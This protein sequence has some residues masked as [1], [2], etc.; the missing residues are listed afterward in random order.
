MKAA[1]IFQSYTQ[2]IFAEAAVS[3]SASPRASY[4]VNTLLALR[5]DQRVVWDQ[6]SLT[7]T[8]DGL[9]GGSPSTARLGDILAIP[10]SN[11]VNTGSPSTLR[12]LNDQRLDQTL[13]TPELLASGHPRTLVV[14]LSIQDADP[15][16]R[17]AGEWQLVIDNPTNITLGG[18]VAL[19]GPKTYLIDRDFQW[20]YT[21]RITAGMFEASNQYLTR[22]RQTTGTI[23]RSVDLSTLATTSDADALEA[24][25]LANRGRPGLL[26]FDPDIM[27]AYLGVWD[28]F[29]RTV[30]FTGAERIQLTFVELS[31]GLVL[32]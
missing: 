27:D 10:M 29:A 7:L 17:T 26:W 1:A 24:W 5:P 12:I 21:T 23:E 16:D 13:A 6:A 28:G 32:L 9:G 30:V 2:N 31:K 19:Y 3:A 15:N 22:Y 25:F 14:D 20:E 8:W 11:L 18:A 4:D